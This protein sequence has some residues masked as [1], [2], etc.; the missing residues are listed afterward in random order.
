MTQNVLRTT[1]T[2]RLG[3]RAL[4]T[5][6]DRG[7]LSPGD[8][9]GI[10][11]AVVSSLQG[12]PI[13]HLVPPGVCQ[14][15]EEFQSVSLVNRVQVS[16]TSSILRF[17]L[18]DSTKSL[19]LSTCACVLAQAK[20]PTIPEPVIRP[21]TPISTNALVG[22][23][24]LLVKNY[25]DQ[26]TMSKFL[27]DIEIGSTSISF[28]HVSFN[29]KIQAPFRQRHII[30]LA[31]GTGITP[32]IQALHSILGVVARSTLVHP[33]RNNQY[34]KVTLLYGS[35]HSQDILARSLLEDW[36]SKYPQQF[37]VVHVLSQE[38]K[39]SAWSGRHGTISRELLQ[40]YIPPPSVL[41]AEGNVDVDDKEDV[42]I[43]VCG[44]PSMYQALCGPRQEM[45]KISGILGEMGY[46][47]RQVYKF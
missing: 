36:A 19:Q 22:Y 10:P 44:P 37:Q 13:C 45:D 5:G 26:G 15:G 32:M 23:M 24:D 7:A 21:Y 35:Q 34:P 12:P 6:S 40:E 46:S 16:P 43:M 17:Q 38:P 29:V 2:S 4:S 8:I 30:M 11:P 1:G 3:W 9:T 33:L 41:G 27:H 20:I 39:D 28:K 18:P 47:A 14:F 42:I 31:G 25:Q